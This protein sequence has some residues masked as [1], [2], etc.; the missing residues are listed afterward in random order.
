MA[1]L[2][3]A[4]FHRYVGCMFHSISDE[5]DGETCTGRHARRPRTGSQTMPLERDE[6]KSEG[7][8]SPQQGRDR[9]PIEWKLWSP[10][11]APCAGE[12]VER[13]RTRRARCGD[14]CPARRPLRE[15]RLDPPLR[16]A[17]PVVRWIHAQNERRPAVID[18]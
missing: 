2:R 1:I 5:R 10:F 9:F 15:P 7:A 8:R 13:G 14:R 4:P 3:A 17:L 16:F 11:L 12:G 18:L 6:G